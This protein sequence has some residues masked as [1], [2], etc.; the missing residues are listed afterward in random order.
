VKQVPVPWTSGRIPHEISRRVLELIYTAYDMKPFAEDVWSDLHLESQ[1]S[2]PLPEPFAWNEER[3]FLIR[4]EIDAMYFHLYGINR[5]DADYIMETFPIVRRK[6]EQKYGEYCTKRVILECYD[7]MAEAMKTDRPYQTILDP[8]PTDP[9]LA[10]PP[11][12]TRE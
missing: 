7:A 3:R 2:P 5:D 9:R 10:H 1:D 11:R 8:P 6:D 4:C 12:G